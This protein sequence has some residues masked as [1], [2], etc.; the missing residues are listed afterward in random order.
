[1]E[2]NELL[3]IVWKRRWLMK[4]NPLISDTSVN[5]VAVILSCPSIS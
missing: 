2:L 5:V 1:M 4:N 3:R